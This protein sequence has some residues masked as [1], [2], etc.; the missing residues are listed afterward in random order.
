MTASVVNSI[1]QKPWNTI[2]NLNREECYLNK[3]E[4]K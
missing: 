1:D 2:D 3:K 4:R